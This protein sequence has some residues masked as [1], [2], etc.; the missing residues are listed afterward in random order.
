MW[1]HE[2]DLTGPL[3]SELYQEMFQQSQFQ[4]YLGAMPPEEVRC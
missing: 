4:V 3:R 1:Y 2:A